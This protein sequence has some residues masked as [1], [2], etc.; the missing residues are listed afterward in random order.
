M[1]RSWIGS[2]LMIAVWTTGLVAWPADAP[3]QLARGEAR[4]PA[5]SQT[6][7][8]YT[9]PYMNPYMNPFLNPYA[10][11]YPMSGPDA[12]FSF[13]A[14]QQATGGIGS[15]RLSGVRP[16]GQ[17]GAAAVA[18]QTPDATM[19]VPGAAA[20]RYFNR[21]LPATGGPPGHYNRPSPY[22]QNFRR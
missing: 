22:Y 15:G 16:A 1:K 6:P 14:A 18:P 17:E 3:A 8:V 12:A 13:F 2:N 11:Q 4:T 21:A 5:G 10:S 20:S 9:N 19:A 7:G